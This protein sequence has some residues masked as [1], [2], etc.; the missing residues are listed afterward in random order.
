MSDPIGMARTT[1]DFDQVE[2]W[3]D[4][5]TPHTLNLDGTYSPISLDIEKTLLPVAPAGVHWSTLEDMARYMET[6]L[7]QGWRRMG[8]R[9]SRRKTCARPG[10]PQIKVTA[11]TSYGLGWMTTTYKGLP[12]ITHGGNTLGFTSDFTFLPEANLGVIVLT[13]ARASNVF[14]QGVTGRVLELIFAQDPQ[15][16]EQMDFY[17]Q[18]MKKQAAEMMA[19]I[20]G[21]ADPDAVAPY[22]GTLVN[23]ALGSIEL[24]MEDGELIL[25]AGEFQ[26]RM[27]EH[28]DDKGQADGYGARRPIANALQVRNRGRRDAK[29]HLGRW[30]CGVYIYPAGI[31]RGKPAGASTPGR[32]RASDYFFSLV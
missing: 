7:A 21:P 14:N 12:V 31:G 10:K 24:R 17:L 30:G 5:A 8:R 11:D 32:R 25:D 27:R 19:Q 15:S 23:D 26:T 16:Q 20:S 9:L 22:L 1:I 29:D 18:L 28:K 2:A 6:E 13:N 4:Y 3:G